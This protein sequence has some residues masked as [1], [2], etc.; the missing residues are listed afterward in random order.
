M[1]PTLYNM[2]DN[3]IDL[4]Y[5]ISLLQSSIVSQP[6]HCCWLFKQ[7]V[8]C[9]NMTEKTQSAQARGVHTYMYMCLESVCRTFLSI[10][11]KENANRPARTHMDC[12]IIH[13]SNLQSIKLLY[14]YSRRD[15]A[16][17]YDSTRQ[18]SFLMSLHFP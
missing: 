2:L 6:A 15:M 10:Y 18:L 12:D 4:M 5:R 1:T 16:K 3:F 14:L 17:H 8:D 13:A 9:R 7:E 11:H